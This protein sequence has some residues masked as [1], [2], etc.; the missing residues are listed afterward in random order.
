MRPRRP[1]PRS[2]PEEF[3]GVYG[4]VVN[5]QMRVRS[6]LQQ[7]VERIGVDLGMP[8]RTELNSVHKRMHD[9]RRELRDSQEAQSNGAHDGRDAEIAA[10]RAEIDDLRRLNLKKIAIVALRKKNISAPAAACT[11]RCEGCSAHR[12]LR[13]P[14][15]RKRAA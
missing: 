13:T 10:M 1:T 12:K 8:T 14:A 2:H 11:G 15:R 3:R 4:D 6:Q 7:E 5:A 9:L